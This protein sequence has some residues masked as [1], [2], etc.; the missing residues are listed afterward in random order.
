MEKETLLHV[1]R[2]M[3]MRKEEEAAAGVEKGRR[4]KTQQKEGQRSGGL[5]A[6]AA[7]G[8]KRREQLQ[9]GRFPWASFRLKFMSVHVIEVVSLSFMSFQR[10]MS[11]SCI[12]VW[13][14]RRGS[15]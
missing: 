4:G 3:R 10:F 12:S 11:V 15:P 6:A 14:V 13:L 1:L 2:H 9:V 7:S 8:G 5:Q